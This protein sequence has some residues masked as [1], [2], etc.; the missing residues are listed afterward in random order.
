M[1]SSAITPPSD[2]SICAPT[3]TYSSEADKFHCSVIPLLYRLLNPTPC[4]TRNTSP[5]RAVTVTSVLYL[6]MRRA[7]KV[8]TD[9]CIVTLLARI[10][11]VENQKMSG[12][13]KDCQ[14]PLTR[15]T[16]YALVNAAKN[17]TMPARASHIL[18]LYG[19]ILFCF[20]LTVP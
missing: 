8:F 16:R 11:A 20:A 6:A 19:C 1:I 13:L 17:I 18:N 2:Y 10:T 4:R 14:A 7:L 9:R 15:I 3:I 5:S 12:M